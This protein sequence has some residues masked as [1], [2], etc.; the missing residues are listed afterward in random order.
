[1]FCPK[2][3]GT[4]QC[5]VPTTELSQTMKGDTAMKQPL[6]AK[7]GFTLIELITVIII[8]AIMLSVAL[9]KYI[10][11]SEKAKAS[12]AKRVL[13]II[14]KAELAF[15][16][17]NSKYSIFPGQ[18]A[19]EGECATSGNPC[20]SDDDCDKN[21]SETCT[22]ATAATASGIDDDVPVRSDSDWTYTVPTA[23]ANEFYAV[24][25][26][27]ETQDDLTGKT[28][29]LDHNGKFHYCDAGA[30]EACPSNDE[31]AEKYWK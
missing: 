26:R 18:A 13:D 28:I 17:E 6:P 1:M 10:K 23:D 12:N 31:Y 21:N 27:G 7:K 4:E 16:V 9:P 5:S 24:A 3:A 11:M 15:Y 25:T 14:R 30:T 20:S 29:L 19:V 22:G 8:I 2:Q